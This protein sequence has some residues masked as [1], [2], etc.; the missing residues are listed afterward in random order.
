MES[1]DRYIKHIQAHK[2][3]GNHFSGLVERASTSALTTHLIKAGNME[4]R[5][6]R[7]YSI[8]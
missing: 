1:I 2:L 6:E 7:M 3:K 8:S 4:L 5:G